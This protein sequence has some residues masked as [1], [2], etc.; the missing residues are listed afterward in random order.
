MMIMNRCLNRMS[1][2]TCVLSR[3]DVLNVLNKRLDAKNL[4]AWRDRTKKLNSRVSV[5]WVQCDTLLSPHSNV[6]FRLKMFNVTHQNLEKLFYQRQ[7]HS[8]RLSNH[9]LEGDELDRFMSFPQK[10]LMKKKMMIKIT[11]DLTTMHCLFGVDLQ[12][13]FN[14]HKTMSNTSYN[15]FYHIC[16]ILR[17]EETF[18]MYS[19]HIM[20][21][22][23]NVVKNKIRW[24]I[25]YG[26]VNM[27]DLNDRETVGCAL[28]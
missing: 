19:N 2:E 13:N 16:S 1:D 22:T 21:T 23:T 3:H 26:K 7:R 24:H 14:H 12:Q 17:S 6:E 4:Q 20:I 10:I 9:H 18:R 5:V 8:N 15:T 11:L 28:D 25:L 27:I